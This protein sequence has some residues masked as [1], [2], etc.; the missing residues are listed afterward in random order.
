MAKTIIGYFDG[1]A[2]A[3]RGVRALIE[4]GFAREDIS[5]IANDSTGACDRR[6]T[7]TPTA[8]E[9]S[10]SGMLIGAGAGAVVGGLG[11]LLV[12]L[13]ALALPGIGP[14]IAAGPLGAALPGAGVGTTAGGIIGALT[15]AGV[16]EEEA[17]Y[18]AEGLRRGGVVVAVR[19]EEPAADRA[20][21]IWRRRGAADIDQ[22]IAEWRHRG[23]TGFDPRA[24]PPYTEYVTQAPEDSSPAGEGNYE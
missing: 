15:D 14:V 22:R 11:G 8:G 5:L 7:A 20:A 6:G 21:D 16:A 12:G 23:W 18:Y 13:G 4:G 10:D 2:Q 3:E 19:A 24:E 17:G 9:A 1:L